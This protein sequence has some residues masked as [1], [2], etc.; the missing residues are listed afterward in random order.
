VDP[1]DH[2][3][4]DGP[5]AGVPLVF[6]LAVPVGHLLLQRYVQRDQPRVDV[7]PAL[8]GQ[9]HRLPRPLHRAVH[10]VLERLQRVHHPRVLGPVF[11]VFGGV[12]E[13][14]LRG[15]LAAAGLALLAP[16]LPR[17]PVEL[18]Q[19]VLR[20]VRGVRGVGLGLG[21]AGGEEVRLQIIGGQRDLA[22][23]DD[24]LPEHLLGG[25]QE[26]ALV[27]LVHR[28]D[29]RAEDGLPR[30]LPRRGAR[31]D[32]LGGVVIRGLQKEHKGV[33]GLHV[34]PDQIKLI[35]APAGDSVRGVQVL[36]EVHHPK[37]GLV[38]LHVGH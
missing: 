24:V 2:V 7:D 5:A 33:G 38:D 12:V 13:P 32:E 25:D 31:Q 9:L 30:T 37:P 36:R 20:G 10:R 28:R 14:V 8:E 23:F 6:A 1:R 22:L 11:E 15:E 35:G 4:R 17:Q 16:A 19:Q 29:H 34:D 26:A 21:L 27:V 18:A 3:E